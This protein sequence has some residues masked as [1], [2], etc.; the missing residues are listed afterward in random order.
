VPFDQILLQENRLPLTKKARYFRWYHIYYILAVFGLATILF[1]LLLT[2]FITQKYNSS[3]DANRQW[4]ERLKSL[5]ELSRTAANVNGPANDVFANQDLAQEKQLLSKALV[6]LDSKLNEFKTDFRKAG[7][8]DR[9]KDPVFPYDMLRLEKR[10]GE[11]SQEAI[12]TVNL[13]EQKK[14]DEAIRQMA[15]MDRRFYCANA[16]FR[17]FSLHISQIQTERF[18]SQSRELEFLRMLERLIAGATVLMI[19]GVTGYGHKMAKQMTRAA[20]EKEYHLLQLQNANDGLKIKTEELQTTLAD[21]QTAQNQ[22]LE[23]E[24]KFQAIFDHSFQFIG[25]TSPDGVLLEVNR[26]ALE[27]VGVSRSDVIGLPFWETPWWTNSTELQERLKQAVHDAAQGKFVRFETSHASKTGNILEVDFSLKPVLDNSGAVVLLIPEG[28]DI[29]EKKQAEVRVSEFYS[30]VSHELRTPLTSIRGSLGL[31]GGGLAGPITD[32][33]QTLVTIA[34]EESDRLIRLINDILDLRKIEAGML[35]LRMSNIRPFDLVERTIKN[36]SG[37]ASRAG[38]NLLTNDDLDVPSLDCDQ[39]RII[40]VLTNIVSNAI[41]FSARGQEVSIAVSGNHHV[42]RFSIQDSGPGIP[43]EQEHKLFGK[44]QQIDQSDRR[45]KD[46]SGLGL[47]ISKA[48]VEQHGGTIGFD[49]RPEGG[50]TFWFELP[51][52]LSQ[53]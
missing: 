39:D 14:T 40:Q 48:L 43:P 10:L 34:C 17:T 4:S 46:G 11:L 30:T 24:R 27:F 36:L 16:A 29:T 13:F 32:K 35:E 28:R 22:I 26:T 38:I 41:K 7:L 2:Q 45:N 50:T 47:A 44:F 9:A 8:L 5:S 1:S 19:L 23:S 31:I 33:T 20:V 25:L 53:N 18:E 15:Y 12:K 49:N 37:I 3:I 6:E 42:V 21:L 52:S 51:L